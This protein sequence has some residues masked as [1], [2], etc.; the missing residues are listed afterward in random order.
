MLLLAA[1]VLVIPACGKS[2]SGFKPTPS[3]LQ[4]PVAVVPEKMKVVVSTPGVTL[5]GS[6][7]Y[8]PVPLAPALTFLWTQTAGTPVTLSLTT[9]NKPTFTAPATPG[10]LTFQLTVTGA[11]G[12]DSASVTVSV[13]PSPSRCPPMPS[14]G[15]S[16][17]ARA[18]R[19]PRR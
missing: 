1:A 19:S 9:P 4:R 7:S 3:A 18:E 14:P 12:T 2:D 16:A 6:K 8:D 11:Q 15:S 10:D 5:D 17:T 13:K